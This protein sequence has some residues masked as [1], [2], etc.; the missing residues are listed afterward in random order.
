MRK[1]RQVILDDKETRDIQRTAKRQQVAV[2]EWVRQAL[3]A[4]HRQ[5]PLTDAKKKRGV[6]C[7]V[8]RHDFPTGDLDQIL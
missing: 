3:L 8:A 5:A 6:V 4:V 7:T 2:A 1:R